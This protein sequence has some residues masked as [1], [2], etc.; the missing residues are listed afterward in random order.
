MLNQKG[1]RKEIRKQKIQHETVVEKGMD[2]ERNYSVWV[3]NMEG[4]IREV[5]RKTSDY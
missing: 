5:S 3:K 2:L 4:F 1:R